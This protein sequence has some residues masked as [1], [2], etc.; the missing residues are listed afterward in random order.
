MSREPLPWSATRPFVDS[1]AADPLVEVLHPGDVALALAGHRLETLLGSCVSII[2]TDTRQTVGAMCH[3]VHAAEPPPQ[4]AG[5]TSYARPA[6]EAMRE[7]LWRVGMTPE[8]CRAYLYGG[9]NMFPDTFSE[10][11]VGAANVRWARA[12][13]QAHGIAI[14]AESTGGTF[15]RKV[16]WTVGQGEPSVQ[17]V[18]VGADSSVPPSQEA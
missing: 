13:L 17:L 2:L 14:L 4:A 6:V 18:A 11:H 12:W 16:S 7:G 10:R 9:G 15:Y 8:F 5:D 1:R 3:I